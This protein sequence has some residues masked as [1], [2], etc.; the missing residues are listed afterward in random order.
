MRSQSLFEV[1]QLIHSM[2]PHEKRY[3]K[4][5]ATFTGKKQSNNYTELF[6]YLNAREKYEEAAFLAFLQA[7]T[8]AAHYQSTLYHL[9]GLLIRS[10]QSLQTNRSEAGKLRELVGGSAD[11]V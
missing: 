8:Y 9:M 6:D 4:L 7:Q 10:L 3:F 5:F 1:H 2:T 11:S